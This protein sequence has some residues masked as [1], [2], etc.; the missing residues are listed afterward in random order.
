MKF[1]IL[2]L[3]ITSCGEKKHTPKYKEGDCARYTTDDHNEF[4][5]KEPS[6]IYIEKVGRRTYLTRY[7]FKKGWY[8]EDLITTTDDQSELVDCK[9]L[10]KND[11]ESEVNK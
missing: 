7:Q 8:S 1:L 11:P 3:L 2:L 10:D 9:L 6:Y 5:K 4:I